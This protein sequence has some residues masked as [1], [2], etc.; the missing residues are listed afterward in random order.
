[1]FSIALKTNETEI[2]Y[3]ARSLHIAKNKTQTKYI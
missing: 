2:R 3:N 1:M